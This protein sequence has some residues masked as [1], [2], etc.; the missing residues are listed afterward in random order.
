MKKHLLAALFMFGCL[1]ITSKADA[2]PYLNTITLDDI[3]PTSGSSATKL[4]D[5]VLQLTDN[6]LSDPS[7]QIGSAYSTSPVGIETFNATFVF[8]YF[9]TYPKHGS[10]DGIVFVIKNPGS[11]TSGGDG[12]GL[13]YGTI[14]T[15]NGSYTGIPNSVGI[16]FDNWYNSEISDPGHNHIGIN[17]NGSPVSMATLDISPEFNGTGLWYSWIDYDGSIL[18]VS[19]NQTNLKPDSAMLSYTIGNIR[20]LIDSPAAMIGFTGSTGWATQ[21]QQVLSLYYNDPPLTPSVPE[22][23]TVVLLGVGGALLTGWTRKKNLE[24]TR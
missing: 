4:P 2:I 13:G 19:V 24:K 22:P 3:S 16:E 14:V 8:Q 11:A 9:G 10:A 12:G 6:S 17:V 5:G 1:G 21:T 20:S 23:G 18:S 15:G 7:Y